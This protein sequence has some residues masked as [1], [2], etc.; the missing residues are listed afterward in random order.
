[1]I[2]LASRAI[3]AGPIASLAIRIPPSITNLL[4]TVASSKV[5]ASWTYTSEAGRPCL[6]YTVALALGDATLY[7]VTFAGAGTSQ[8][9]PYVLSNGSTYTLTVSVSDGIDSVSNTVEFT[10][11]AATLDDIELNGLVGSTY[12][13]AIDGVGYMLADT[14]LRPYRRQAGELTAPRFATGTTPF[15]EAIERYTLVGLADFRSGT[16][17]PRVNPQDPSTSNGFLRSCGVDVSDLGRLTLLP[18]SVDTGLVAPVGAVVASGLMF[19]FGASVEAGPSDWRSTFN[20]F[21]G[22]TASATNEVQATAALTDVTTDGKYW[23]VCDGVDIYRGS[24]VAL[25]TAAW[26]TVGATVVEWCGDRL[27]CGYLDGSGNAAFSTL[28]DDGTEEVIGGRSQ[29]PDSTITSITSGDGY[30]WFTVLKGSATTVYSYQLGSTTAPA[31]SLSLPT[32]ERVVGLGFYLGSVMIRTALGLEQSHVYR[33]VPSSGELTPE[34]VAVIENMAI[35]PDVVHR[36]V[37]R[38]RFVFF[39]TG[40]D[41]GYEDVAGNYSISVGAIDLATGGWTEHMLVGAAGGGDGRTVG[42]FEGRLFSSDPAGS[43]YLES[44]TAF[45]SAGWLESSSFD[46][47]SGLD[48]VIDEV[49]IVV[50]PLPAGASVAVAY[51]SNG[52]GSFLDLGSLST[53]GLQRWSES[54]NA[55]VSSVAVRFDLAAASS[56]PVVARAQIKLHPRSLADLILQLPI[57]CSRRRNG[58]NGAELDSQEDAVARSRRLEAMMGARVIVQ[59]VDWT[60]DR[61]AHEWEVVGTEFTSLGVF[62]RSRSRRSEITPVCVM[63]LRRA[64]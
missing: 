57:D 62:D 8:L 15:S 49:D 6:S 5:S 19:G 64:L 27:A 58:L 17:I 22:T 48:K 21:D 42:V 35:N 7:E 59:D 53:A 56:P 46:L 43:V 30:V 3:A 54:V 26:S 20:S 44:K 11:L 18:D 9:V 45:L 38:D 39:S 24:T 14:P 25:T 10:V 55:T 63:T 37:G 1:M 31:V 12:E 2:S 29:F 4:E 36:F 52:G 61:E 13:I 33:A 28:A 47:G 34:R 51:S 16:D 50:A 32:G 40:G 41:L 23:Y 60:R